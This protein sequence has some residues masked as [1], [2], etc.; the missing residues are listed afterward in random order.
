MTKAPISVLATS[1]VAAVTL[2]AVTSAAPSSSAPVTRSIYFSATDAKNAPVTDLTAADITVK[3]GGKAVQIDKV[4]PATAPMHIA[5]IVD[6]NGSGGYQGAIVQVIQA[7]VSNAQFS[8]RVLNPQAQLVQDFTKDFELLKA[9]VNRVGPRGTARPDP[10]QVI[11]GIAE[12]SKDFVTRKVERP[13]ILVITSNGDSSQTSNVDRTIDVLKDSKAML[14]L[15]MLSNASLGRLLGD[16]PKAS[17]GRSE[18]I[19]GSAGIP[20]ATQRIID[21]LTKQYVVT[22][23]LPE[24]TKPNE[25][26]QVATSRKG[27]TLTAPSRLSEK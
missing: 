4:A 19:G 1:I 18:P 6:D 22:Y 16:G 10:D 25:R 7:M 17:G 3:E 14:N 8:F 13:V 5:V 11:E 21:H 26:V 20:A 27:V 9:A 12:A 24:G 23:T 15:L 2:S